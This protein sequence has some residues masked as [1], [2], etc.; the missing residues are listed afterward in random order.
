MTLP[1][2]DAMVSFTSGTT[3]RPKG[4]VFTWAV[5]FQRWRF[6]N[7][8]LAPGIECP[9][10][11][12]FF[13]PDSTFGVMLMANVSHGYPQILL[14]PLAYR[15]DDLLRELARFE[16]NHLIFPSQLAR[17]VSSAI[18]E[19]SPSIPTV[20]SI[21]IGGEGSRFELLSGL[22]SVLP[23]KAQLSQSLSS[24]EGGRVFSY[25]VGLQDAPGEGQIP[26]GHPL[27]PDD[28]RLLVAPGSPEGLRQVL[29]AGA[30]ADRY[31]DDPH[32]TA[33]RFT[34]AEDG[35]RWWSSGDLVEES[36]G[37]YWHRGRMD[38]I[39]KVQGR[40]ASPAEVAEAIEALDGVRQAV[41][42]PVTTGHSTRLV[43][44]MEVAD[45]S[46]LDPESIRS[47]LVE[48]LPAHL[49]PSSFRR[50]KQLPLSNRGKIDRNKLVDGFIPWGK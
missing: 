38:D 5:L 14:D 40:V 25:T 42:V 47:A 8:A 17:I 34:L 2:D 4:L 32:R 28:I 18:T 3:A 13:A 9:R 20:R 21:S 48:V 26:I 29:V 46:G 31:L 10:V 33:E 22:R 50:H 41:V 49:I 1:T 36:G 39:V 12:M 23:A 43:A 7:P 45:S 6:R 37:I 16:P 27:F 15:P 44:H 11:G 24:S 19:D 35:T 30:I